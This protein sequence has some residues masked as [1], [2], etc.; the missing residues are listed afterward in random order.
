MIAP[1]AYLNLKCFKSTRHIASTPQQLYI[2][3]HDDL[4]L[5]KLFAVLI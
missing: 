1:L 2:H 3:V 4:V 5:L